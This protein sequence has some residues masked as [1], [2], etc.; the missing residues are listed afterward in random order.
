MTVR[1]RISQQ[2]FTIL[3]QRR[4]ET[5]P[6]FDS[7]SVSWPCRVI[8]IYDKE[9]SGHVLHPYAV[10]GRF[11]QY[12]MMQKIWK[13]VKTL[14]NECSYESTQQELSNEYQH[15]RVKM[16]FK[17]ICILVRWT[18]VAS[19]FGGLIGSES[20]S[21]SCRV[22]SMHLWGKLS[23]AASSLSSSREILQLESVT[24]GSLQ[25]LILIF[26]SATREF[27]YKV[28]K[29]SLIVMN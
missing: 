20:V 2:P 4:F 25:K 19:A 23:S 9:D 8:A 18:N 5:C 3:P 6:K 1:I 10:G 15:D 27:V 14:V 21:C 16:F 13:M 12:K 22:I 26:P 24:G 11:S 7:E 17:N 29:N 28:K